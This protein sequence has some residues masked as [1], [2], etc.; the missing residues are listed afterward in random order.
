MLRS[1]ALTIIWICFTVLAETR[2]SFEDDF[3][4]FGRHTNQ[5]LLWAPYR[6][7]CY[8]GIRPRF[9]NENP[10]MMGLMW[11][12]ASE[13]Q[14]LNQLRHFVDIGDKLEKYS[15]E[16]YDPR[17]GGKEVIIDR[18]NNLNLTIHFAKSRNGENWGARISGEPLDPTKTKVPSLVMYFSQNGPAGNLGRDSTTRQDKNGIYLEGS[19]PELGAY[20]I[21]IT[22]NSGEYYSGGPASE[23]NGDSTKPSH[24]SFTV[25]DDQVWKARDI[26]QTML[27]ESIQQIVASGKKINP[28]SL[29]SALMLRNTNNFPPGSFHFVQKTFD[30]KEPFEFDIIFN[31]KGSKQ[32]ISSRNEFSTLISWTMSELEVRFNNKFSI[33]DLNLKQFAEETLANLMG[34]IGYF[35]GTQMVDRTTEFDEEQFEKIELKA[36]K[37]EGPLQLFS[38]VPSR[39]FFPRGFYWDE[40]FHLLQMMEYDFDLALE[41]LQ[42]WFALIEDDSGWVARELI[43]GSEARSKVPEEFQVQNPN[44]ANPPTLLLCFSEM[45]ARAL[46]YQESINKEPEDHSF[47]ASNTDELLKRPELLTLFAKKV[48]PKLLKHYEW[49][50]NSQRGFIE[51]Y[52]E[53]LHNDVHP[54]EAFRWVGRT[55]THCLPS[56][57]D[58][59]PRAQPPDVA[60][61]HLDALAWAGVMTR[62]MKQIS[63]V[64][65]MPEEFERFSQT[66]KKIIDNLD[67]IHWSEE[68]HCYYDVT[69]D[70]DK[71]ELR[72]FV[73][74]EGYVSLMPFALKLVPKKSDKLKWFLNSM[75]D[76]EK[77]FSD[78]G[79]LSLSRKDEVFETGEVYWRGPVWINMNYLL[80][81][82]LVFYFQQGGDEQDLETVQKAQKLY[83]DLRTNLIANMYRVWGEDGYVYENY[84]HDTGKGTG[85]QHF[86]GWS[87]LIVNILGILPERL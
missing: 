10:L 56:G 47:T 17:L 78:Y 66:E 22:D 46:E 85:V 14:G 39:A 32:R 60:E 61:L 2:P 9:V 57:L 54:E 7:N 31:K 29:P 76:N 74:H 12:D 63:K 1:L 19:A 33:K 82:S 48:Y 51:E 38:S 30:F 62:S 86:T 58:D 16:R 3:Q 53:V 4:E 67:Y 79:I 71:D 35:Y 44:I 6:S 21:R 72:Q 49:W 5:S 34:G 37:E 65:D 68:D 42:S 23:V 75:G 11:F 64:L 40:G 81:D 25:P 52:L 26:F 8:F 69:I 77:L 59:Y 50:T 41:I 87:S 27:T 83:S 36:A 13:P 55:F 45:L 43:L 24:I 70:D 73:R 80:L 15:Y 20:D 18:E 28:M 84:N